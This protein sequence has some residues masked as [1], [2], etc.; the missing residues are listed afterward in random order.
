MLTVA[1]GDVRFPDETVVPLGTDRGLAA[2]ERIAAPT[3]VEQFTDIYPLDFDLDARRT[4]WFDPGRA[5]NDAFF[6][7]LYFSSREAAAAVVGR[8]RP[9]RP[10]VVVRSSVLRSGGLWDHT[11]EHVWG[12][13]LIRSTARAAYEE[14]G[15]GPEDVHVIECHDA[16][17]IGE[18][19][20]TE[21]IGLAAEGQGHELLRNGHTSVGGPQPVN[22]SGGLLSRGHPLGATGVAQA[23]EIVWQLQGRTGGRQVDGARI[24]LIETMGGGVAGIDG[25]ACAIII[26]EGLDA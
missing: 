21:A 9:G 10:E 14:A 23:A 24:G 26:L 8:Q 11:S 1:G 19:V 17:T 15:L 5:R 3:V 16:F 18:I 2:R 22:P 6:R 20:T 12:F 4:P 7:A 25:N 13:D